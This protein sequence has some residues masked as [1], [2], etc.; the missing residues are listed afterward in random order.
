MRGGVTSDKI[1]MSKVTPQIKV[2]CRKCKTC[3]E[4]LAHILGQCVY[5]KTQRIRLHDAI[6]D[7]VDTKIWA[8]KAKPQ[9]IEEALIPTPKGSNLKPDLVVVSQGRVHVIDVTVRHE[10]AGYLYEGDRSK[11]QKYTPLLH[12]LADQLQVSIGRVLPLVI[13]TRGCIPPSTIE[14][15]QE[16]DVSVT[17]HDLP[18]GTEGV[19]RN[20]PLLYGLRRTDYLNNHARV[21]CIQVESY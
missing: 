21:A 6:R 13:G 14:A 4:S 8:A 7:F 15:L 10:D 19:N 12:Q 17:R 5:T 3:N 11:L 18:T 2:K 1:T 9:I 16:L 20:I